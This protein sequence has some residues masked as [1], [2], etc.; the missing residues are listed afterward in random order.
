[1]P[2]ISPQDAEVMIKEFRKHENALSRERELLE[3]AASKLLTG[4]ELDD[5]MDALSDTES[6]G[7]KYY[8][9]MI[10]VLTHGSG[11][12]PFEA[13]K[14]KPY[15]RCLFCSKSLMFEGIM[16]EKGTVSRNGSSDYERVL[17]EKIVSWIPIPD[18]A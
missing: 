7:R 4:K 1:M 2:Y 6:K 17:G 12:I 14:P 8:R 3:E 9:A 18:I 10:D 16:T 15:E 5:Y 13:V 11:W